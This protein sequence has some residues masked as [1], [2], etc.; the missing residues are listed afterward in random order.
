MGL[1]EPV[2]LGSL[3][4]KYIVNLDRSIFYEEEFEPERYYEIYSVPF[5]GG[6]FLVDF[7]DRG[8]KRVI[9]KT[10]SPQDYLVFEHK[11]KLVIRMVESDRGE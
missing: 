4:G 5:Y 6:S 3:K 8:Q 1:N 11:L 2:Y 10:L 9:T 7:I